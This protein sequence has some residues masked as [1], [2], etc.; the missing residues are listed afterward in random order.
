MVWT[1]HK[2]RFDHMN[3][4][5]AERQDA[6][7]QWSRRR[8]DHIPACPG[9]GPCMQLAPDWCEAVCVSHEG[10]CY[11]PCWPNDFR[12]CV[13]ESQ[14]E[15]FLTGTS[16][17]RCAVDI[18]GPGFQEPCKCYCHQVGQETVCGHCGCFVGGYACCASNPGHI[19]RESP[20]GCAPPAPSPLA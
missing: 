17:E 6:Q 16:S 9:S 3:M 14:Y 12:G 18:C 1:T 19:D 4:T 15:V 11:F 2:I 5:D 20:R 8:L 13:S 10:A 7:R